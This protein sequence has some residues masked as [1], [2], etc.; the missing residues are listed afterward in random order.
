MSKKC[1]RCGKTEKIPKEQVLK[2]DVREHPVCSWCWNKFRK[3]FSQA[4]VNSHRYGTAA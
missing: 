4:Q 3:W 2:F 1:K